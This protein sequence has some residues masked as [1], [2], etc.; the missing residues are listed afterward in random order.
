MNADLRSSV[1]VP[2]WLLH[3]DELNEWL[4]DRPPHLRQWLAAQNF[5]AERHRVV[6]VPDAGGRIAAAVGGLGKRHG[7]LSLWDA[8]GLCE[9][10]PPHRFALAQALPPAEATQ[11]ALG[12]AYAAYRFDRYRPGRSESIATLDA[13][14]GA[15][16]PYVELAAA[17]LAMARDWI[18]TPAADFGPAEL[19]AAARELGARHGAAYREWVGPELLT[20]NFPAIHAVG[21]ASATPPR[22]I[23][24]RWAPPAATGA[25]PRP[26][27]ALV[28]K[29]V[30]FDTGGL[31]LKPGTGMALMK[32][33]MGGA[34]VAL[35]LAHM[36]MSARVAADLLVLVPAVENSVGGNAYRPGDVLATRKGLT[37]EVGNTDAEGR[38]VLGDAIAL[39]DAEQPD[40]LI[41][42]ATLTGAARVALGPEVPALFGSDPDVVAALAR[43]AS[44]EHDVLW[45]MPL[46]AP[47]DE[48]LGSKV[49]DLNNVSASAFAGAIF[50]ALFLKRF[51][52]ASPRWLHIDLYAWNARE[53][54]GRGVGAEPQG[55]RALYRYLME[56]YGTA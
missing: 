20:A 54:P 17:A 53:R 45:P 19:A 48:E 44:A 6:L 22:L 33:D 25:A 41:D 37:V 9:R 55:V 10:L 50:G 30:C 28:G 26:K 35:A 27:V 32:K 8:A 4:G 18:N 52:T 11:V 5:K 23:E 13:P 46:W 16:A 14:A 49:A 39:A 56:R 2:L 34:A 47:Y 3:D 7:R 1:P 21:R 51:V 38:L 31:D 24:L 43:T 40:L 12:F 15:D 36:L 42:L 29:G